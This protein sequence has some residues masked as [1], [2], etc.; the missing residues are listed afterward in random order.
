MK[1]VSSQITNP[2]YVSSGDFNK[3]LYIAHSFS[4]NFIS[5]FL[6]CLAVLSLCNKDHRNSCRER[7]FIPQNTEFFIPNYL[8]IMFELWLLSLALNFCLRV[9]GKA[10]FLNDKILL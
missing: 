8:L 4:L 6:A 2:L 1:E 7:G 10:L 9:S 3:H 5:L